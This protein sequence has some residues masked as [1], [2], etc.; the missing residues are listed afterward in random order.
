MNCICVSLASAL[1][2]LGGCS[3]LLPRAEQEVINPWKDFAEALASYDKIVPYATHIEAVRELGF[4]PNHSANTQ[5]L[6]QAQ[7]V[8]AV[9]PSPLQG[10][11]NPPQGIVDCIKAQ[12]ACTGYLMEPSKITQTRVGSF[13][14]DFL[15]FKRNTVTSGWRFSALVVVVD[16]V[17]VYKQWSGEP[18]IESTELRINPLGPLQSMGET[19]KV[20]P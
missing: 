6:N 16:D 9:L 5:V 3:H 1:V 19:L 4:A 14:L 20:A 8:N 10:R 15:N 12:E 17:V 11:M 13:F 18:K 2:L 7:V